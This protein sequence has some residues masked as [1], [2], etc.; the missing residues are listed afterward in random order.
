[1]MSM[2]NCCIGM[3]VLL[4]L[5]TACSPAGTDDIVVS[6]TPEQIVEQLRESY[7]EQNISDYTDC[8]AD[9][10]MF[11]LH[12]QDWEWNQHDPDSCWFLSTELAYSEDL[13][14]RTQGISLELEC[15]PTYTWPDDSTALGMT[16]PFDLEVYT[17]SS[18]TM[19]YRAEGDAV[20]RFVEVSDEVWMIDYWKD[21]SDMSGTKEASTWGFIKTTYTM[22]L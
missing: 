15:T 7:L 2:L 22:N 16:C 5:I 11:V 20:F 1:M 13:L 18:H 14:L 8:F 9:S 4:L 3:S 17:D 12:E 21:Q 10:F 6:V 19:G